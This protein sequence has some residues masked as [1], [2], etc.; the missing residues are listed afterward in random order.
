MSV[1]RMSVN[2]GSSTTYALTL[3]GQN[4]STGETGAIQ[5]SWIDTLTA[6]LYDRDTD[7]VIND[8]EEQD[9]LNANGGTMHA[10]SGAFSLVLGADDNVIVN[11]AKATEVHMLLLELVLTN[12]TGLNWE[13]KVVVTNLHLVP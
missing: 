10:T 13:R 4:P 7:E 6:T 8:R 11:D 2:E 9:V 3:T 5:L 12:D 1:L